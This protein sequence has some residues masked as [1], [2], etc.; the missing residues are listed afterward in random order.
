M[1]GAS[2]CF[3]GK[4]DTFHTRPQAF[5]AEVFYISDMAELEMICSRLVDDALHRWFVMFS[6][7]MIDNHRLPAARLE[8]QPLASSSC[9]VSAISVG[10]GHPRRHFASLIIPYIWQELRGFKILQYCDGHQNPLIRVK[11]K[12]K[13]WAHY[14]KPGC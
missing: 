5:R 9:A 6:S 1:P 8:S 4:K 12:L 3:G 14:T 2:G 10:L 13:R 11:L 7:V